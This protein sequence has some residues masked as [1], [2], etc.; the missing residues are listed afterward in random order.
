VNSR[1][2]WHGRFL[3]ARA[4]ILWRRVT[5]RRSR[6]GQHHKVEQAR[7]IVAQALGDAARRGG[8]AWTGPGSH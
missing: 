8:L 3:L 1:P 4:W 6:S 5:M 7:A 2:A